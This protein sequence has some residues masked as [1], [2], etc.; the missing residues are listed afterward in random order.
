VI[1]QNFLVVIN[2]IDKEIQRVDALT[3]PTIDDRPFISSNDPR[4]DIEWKD[5]LGA[6]FIA[7]D[8]ERDAHSKQRL[9]GCLLIHPQLAV[10]Q[11]SDPLKQ[12][13]CAGS[14]RPIRLE[15]LVVK[16]ASVVPVEKHKEK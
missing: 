7:I 1:F 12:H 14:R 9:L 16:T 10:V 11:G 6:G 3:Q 13:A 15:H 4:N 5:L 2:V 8:I